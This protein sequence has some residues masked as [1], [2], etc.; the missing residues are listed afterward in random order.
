MT[1]SRRRFL[2]RSAAATAG[3]LMPSG[4]D[5]LAARMAHAAGA[6]SL[7]APGY[8]PL[9]RDPAK[10]LDLPKGFQYRALSTATGASARS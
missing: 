5:L 2:R 1:L 10:L 9:Q 6:A 8:G 3:I 7:A 4:L